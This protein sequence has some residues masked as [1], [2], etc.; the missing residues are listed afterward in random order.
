[1]IQK[2]LNGGL[3][4]MISISKT[5]S[6]LTVVCVETDSFLKMSQMIEKKFN[7]QKDGELIMDIVGDQGFQK[8]VLRD[9]KISIGWA[10]FFPF[11]ILAETEESNILVEEIY[12]WL[13]TIL[14]PNR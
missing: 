10:A 8:Y 5:S 12:Q 3:T 14:I 11:D 13:K 7:L 2:Q 9:M 4:K 1:M 6:N